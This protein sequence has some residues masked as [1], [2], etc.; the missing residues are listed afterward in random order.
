M[1][2]KQ[3]LISAAEQL[4]QAAQANHDAGLKTLASGQLSAAFELRN[5]AAQM[6]DEP[7][8]EITV[9]IPDPNENYFIKLAASQ[10]FNNEPQAETIIPKEGTRE[11]EIYLDTLRQG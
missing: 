8:S 1:Q 7:L 6:P 2:T 11:W 3:N 4:E 10:P 9:Q 5:Q